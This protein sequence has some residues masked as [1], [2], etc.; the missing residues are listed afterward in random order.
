MSSLVLISQQIAFTFK[1]KKPQTKKPKPFLLPAESL[2][3]SL[4]S[5]AEGT[6]DLLF[7]FHYSQIIVFF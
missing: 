2:D 1:G 6:T 4:I 5:G 7:L 3:N